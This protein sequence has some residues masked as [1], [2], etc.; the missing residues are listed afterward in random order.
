MCPSLATDRDFASRMPVFGYEIDDNDI[1]PY[2]AAGGVAAGA[3]HVGAWFLNPVDPPLDAN[4]QV[5]QNQE[6][7]YVTAFARTGNPTTNG[8]PVWPQSNPANAEEMSLQPAGDSEVVT[9][10]RSPR[11]T[12]AHS[13]TAS[14]PSPDTRLECGHEHA[15]TRPQLRR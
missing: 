5:L 12:T 6:I 4:Q 9:A 13:G 10:L 14:P 8:A 2:A 11:N 3:S 1:P 7:E 15:R